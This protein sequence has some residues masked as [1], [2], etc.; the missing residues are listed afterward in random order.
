M[1]K[2]FKTFQGFPWL[3]ESP[4][5]TKLLYVTDHGNDTCIPL[6]SRS[7]MNGPIDL[8]AVFPV[9]FE[10]HHTQ[11][12]EYVLPNHAVVSP[13]YAG[14]KDLS[15]FQ[16]LTYRTLVCLATKAFA[17]LKVISH[18]TKGGWVAVIYSLHNFLLFFFSKSMK[19]ISPEHICDKQW[20]TDGKFCQK[21]A[22]VEREITLIL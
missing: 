11:S 18:L 12:A 17:Y 8:K 13:S 22:L 10:S 3:W 5:E 16:M 21:S 20:P 1:F 2:N 9:G 7:Q 4:D 15:S 14:T 6:A 19:S